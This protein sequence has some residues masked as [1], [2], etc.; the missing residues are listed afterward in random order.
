MSKIIFYAAILMQASAV[1]HAAEKQTY[2]G[3]VNKTDIRLIS[4]SRFNPKDAVKKNF[5]DGNFSGWVSSDSNWIIKGRVPHSR[6]LCVTYEL[7]V[8]LGKGAPACLN[9]KWITAVHYGTRRSQ[10]NSAEMQHT[11]GGEVPEFKTRLLEAT[12]VRIV[13]KCSGDACE[14]AE[15]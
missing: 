10:C 6:L 13:T 2:P 5:D 11:G 7:G 3:A 9:V 1:T 4:E 12:C 8:Q 14:G 15:K